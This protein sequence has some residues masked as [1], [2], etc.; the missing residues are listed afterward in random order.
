MIKTTYNPVTKI[1]STD[2]IGKID[3]KEILNYISNLSIEDDTYSNLLYLENQT[4]AEFIFNP[5]EIK[6]IVH[7]LYAK[8]KNIPSLRVAVLNT[9]PKE[10]AFS[11]IAIRLLKAKN[12]H[13]KVFCTK[14][15]ALDWLLVKKKISSN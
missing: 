12:V 3:A 6:Q 7:S 11:L 1:I 13:A 9:H 10:T 4:Q 8:I 14:E 5:S 15:A 2:Y